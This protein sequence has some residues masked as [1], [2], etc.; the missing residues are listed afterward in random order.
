M[1]WE[2]LLR[3]PEGATLLTDGLTVSTLNEP[4]MGLLLPALSETEPPMV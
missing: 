2:E 3:S 1:V 4:L